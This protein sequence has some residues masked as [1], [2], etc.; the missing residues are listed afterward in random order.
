MDFLGIFS[1]TL[2]LFL[3]LL[4][5]LNIYV[6][7]MYYKL[8]SR[9]DAMFDEIVRSIK[10]IQ[11]NFAISQIDTK[12]PI[13]GS[14]N[15]DDELK[16][17]NISPECLNFHPNSPSSLI[18]VSSEY[19]TD[20]EDIDT[21]ND[22]NEDIDTD[23]DEDIDIDEDESES[24][25]DVINYIN[26]FDINGECDNYED[27][28]NG[29]IKNIHVSLE[30]QDLSNI[31][32]SLIGSPV[33]EL[34]VDELPVDELPVDELPVDELPVDELPVDELPVD[35]LPVDE[36]P[37]DELPVDESP[38]DELPINTVTN[39]P[40]VDVVAV[41]LVDETVVNID[42]FVPVAVSENVELVV[43]KRQSR[44][45][46]NE[47]DY[48]KMP[49]NELKKYAGENG[50]VVDVS[51]MKKNEII[52]LIEIATSDIINVI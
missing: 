23:D 14:S 51:K 19:D 48:K 16:E 5:V 18:E 46:M 30:H 26:E 3:V 2:L 40:D 1:S 24:E 8:S 36:L 4:I 27:D 52:K 17:V 47:G 32:V 49:L 25:N 33:D 10:Q 29:N 39:E 38:V 12:Y 9:C 45:N 13:G 20:G 22:E 44:K 34:P 50:V 37:V 15:G 28:I 21:D 41:K 43:K 31:N 11:M 6:I 42:E 35:E 7:N